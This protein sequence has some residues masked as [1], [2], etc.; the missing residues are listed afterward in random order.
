MMYISSDRLNKATWKQ[1]ISITYGCE[2]Y[3]KF[4]TFQTLKFVVF[5]TSSRL[6]K[7]AL[8]DAEKNTENSSE[9]W[10]SAS[11]KYDTSLAFRRTDKSS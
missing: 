1:F 10:L 5:G 6:R 11:A 2:A 3:R 4:V 7:Q 8:R 9:T